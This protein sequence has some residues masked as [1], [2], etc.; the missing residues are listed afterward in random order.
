MWGGLKL[1]EVGPEIFPGVS[2][3]EFF[4]YWKWGIFSPMFSS[5]LPVEMVCAK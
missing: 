4:S 3:G 1:A 5:R 2:A